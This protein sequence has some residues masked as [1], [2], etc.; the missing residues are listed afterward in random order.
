MDVSNFGV[1]KD[2]KTCLFDFDFIGLLPQSFA[3]YNVFLNAQPFITE[4]A[5]HLDWQRTPN[6]SSMSKIRGILW[7]LGDPTLGMST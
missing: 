1:D 3:V 7:V 6:I 5:R 4:V 2:G